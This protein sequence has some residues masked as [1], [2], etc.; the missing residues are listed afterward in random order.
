MRKKR[1]IVPGAKPKL[2][3]DQLD[4]ALA[5]T[6]PASDPVSMEEPA[7]TDDEG[8]PSMGPKLKRAAARRT[9]GTVL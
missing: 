2:V 8:A 6:F 9:P 5:D 7:P 4:E 3:D 1:L